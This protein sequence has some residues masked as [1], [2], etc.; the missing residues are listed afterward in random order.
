MAYRVHALSIVIILLAMSPHL[1]SCFYQ[2]SL[3][4]LN[5]VPPIPNLIPSIPNLAPPVPNISPPIPNIAPCI[6]NLVSTPYP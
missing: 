5:I 2:I 1:F 6:P 4:V 3:L